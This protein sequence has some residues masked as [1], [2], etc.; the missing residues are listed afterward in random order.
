MME[1]V[2]TSEMS[3]NLYTYLK[4]VFFRQITVICSDQDNIKM[5]LTKAMCERTA[6]GT[7]SISWFWYARSRFYHNII[8]VVNLHAKLKDS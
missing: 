4:G 3:V 5:D 8:N 2:I 7:T 1:A 6:D